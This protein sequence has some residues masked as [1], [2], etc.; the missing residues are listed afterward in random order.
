MAPRLQSPKP[1]LNRK[2]FHQSPFWLGRRRK[3]KATFFLLAGKVGE[4]GF[5]SADQ[6][7][8]IG[9]DSLFSIGSQGVDHCRWPD[10]DDARLDHELQ[11]SRKVLGELGGCEITKAGL[12]FGRYDRRVL[13]R[14]ARHGYSEVYSSDGGCRLIRA[15]PLPRLSVEKQYSL[16]YLAM[17]IAKSGTLMSRL[18]REAAARIKGAL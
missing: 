4:P 2:R 8:E 1:R 17:R 13:K 6:I 10:L 9:A 7:R 12:P 5:L 18:G 3:L 11:H 16:D 15:N 14:L